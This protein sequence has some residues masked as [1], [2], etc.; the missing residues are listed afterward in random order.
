MKHQATHTLFFS[1]ELPRELRL[2]S[3]LG[4]YIYVESQYNQEANSVITENIE[5]FQ[6]TLKRF[7]Y[8]PQVAQKV[9]QKEIIEYN[10]PTLDYQSKE[11]I[12]TPLL[13]SHLYAPYLLNHRDIILQPGLMWHAYK[14]ELNADE[15]ELV[16]EGYIPYFYQPFINTS[17]LGIVHTL[18]TIQDDI[19][20]EWEDEPLVMYSATRSLGFEEDY[21][22]QDNADQ[23]FEDETLYDLL[24]EVR[25][26]IEKLRLYGVEEYVLKQLVEPK[27]KLSCL[28]ITK[29]YRIFLPDYNNIEIQMTPLPKAVY[30]LFL[31]HPEGILFKNLPDYRQELETI[32]Y[33]ITHRLDDEKIKESIM[34][35]TDPTDNSIN[36]KCS[37][38]REAFLSHFTE[39]LAKKYYI[40]GYKFSP[41]RITLPRELITFEQ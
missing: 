22:P 38:I 29:D 30:L 23:N 4:C 27:Y 12:T 6:K 24:N 9:L 14:E 36:E 26:K 5:E 7:F 39:E 17:Y 11:D 32:Y 35:V 15:K 10:V 2:N 31:N 20:C 18:K 1:K 3:D 13:F 41:K 34:R 37:R 25:T 8:Y 28:H 16:N 19:D 40:T 21:N 33:A